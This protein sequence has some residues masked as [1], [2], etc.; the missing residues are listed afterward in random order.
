MEQQQRSRRRRIADWMGIS[1]MVVSLWAPI[2]V[3][4]DAPLAAAAAFGGIAISTGA[5]RVDDKNGR[6]PIAFL[7]VV[8]V[9]VGA[10]VLHW[11][12]A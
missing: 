9:A 8:A 4:L 2:A 3:L 1:A 7:V 10:L 12:R 6:A 5:G 11:T